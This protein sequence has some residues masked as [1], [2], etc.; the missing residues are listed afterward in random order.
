MKPSTLNSLNTHILPRFEYFEPRSLGEALELLDKLGSEARIL[1]GGTDLLV[2]M[3]TGAL[4]PRYLINIKR[5][6]GLRYI[7]VE[8]GYQIGR[9]H[10]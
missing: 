6:P 9:A 1:A 4:R 8:E 2:K 5:I 10:V 3:K 7:R